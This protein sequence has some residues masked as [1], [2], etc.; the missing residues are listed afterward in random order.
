MKVVASQ[1]F[2]SSS[3]PSNRYIFENRT[4]LIDIKADKQFTFKD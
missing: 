2:S 1:S 3:N 4:G